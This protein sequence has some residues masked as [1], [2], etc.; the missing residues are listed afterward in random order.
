MPDAPR[1]LNELWLAQLLVSWPANQGPDTA[2]LDMHRLPPAHC[3]TITPERTR[4]QRY[5]YLEHTPELRLSSDD[6]YVE[7][8]LEIYTEAVRGCLR[9]HR[10]VGVSLS[11]GLDSGSVTAL[12][13]RELR[14]QGKRL[15]AFTSA[16][17]FSVSEMADENHFG[18]ES[19]FAEATARFAGNVD[20]HLVRA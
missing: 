12:A 2:Y 5:W 4:V 9:S 20:H 16:P 17:A 15:Q 8:L 13:A 19:P 6:E 1:R 11:G 3:M 18:D 7:A 14:Q 10:P